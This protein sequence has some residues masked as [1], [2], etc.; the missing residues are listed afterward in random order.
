MAIIALL[1]GASVVQADELNDLAT[2][3]MELSGTREI[4]EGLG[5]SL[6]RE[7]TSDPRLEKLSKGQRAELMDVLKSALDGRRIEQE[8]T[9]ALV[10][11]GDRERL[12]EAVAAM[13]DPIYLKVTHRVVVE[14]L[15][16]TP[17]ALAAYAK[18][19][20]KHPPDP[21][22]VQLIQRLDTA[23]GG[24][25]ILADTRYEMVSKTLGGM[26]TEA[27][28]DARLAKLREQID[29]SAPNEYLLLTLYACRKIESKDLQGY[30]HAHENEPMGWLSRQLGYAI[31][32]SMVNAMTRMAEKL[33]DLT[34]K[35]P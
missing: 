21:E 18:G 11:S 22:R 20:Q 13:H 12:A 31:Q 27:D 5:K 6:D 4:L 14:S 32:R 8:L 29:V 24:S 34:A 1:L 2:Q 33:V 23:T 16:T 3:A 28:R 10:A 25:R 19:F 17:Q 7:V 30:V 26:L 15:N 9:S 35:G